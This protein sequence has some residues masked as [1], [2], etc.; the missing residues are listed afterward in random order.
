MTA[1]DAYDP[2]FFRAAGHRLVD[3]LSDYLQRARAGELPVLDWTAPRELDASVPHGFPELGDGDVVEILS[4]VVERSNHLHHPSYVG[5]QVAT[6]LPVAALAE[7]TTALLNN[8]MAIYEMGP[9]QT[10]MERRVVAFL[11]N[12]VGLPGEADGILT[13]GGSLGNLTALLAARRVASAANDGAPPERLAILA[14]D[15]AHYSIA[16]AT[17]TLGLGHGAAIAVPSDA[18]F[19]LSVEELSTCLR[20]AQDE[21][22]QVL[23]VV[24][25]SCSTA[26]GSFDPLPEIADFCAEHGLW[27]HVDAAH[28]ASLALSDRHRD[29]LRGIERADSVVWD[30]HKMMA[31]PA[32]NTAVLFRDRGHSYGTFA[33]EAGYLFASDPAHDEWWNIGLRTFECTKRG[34]GVTAYCMLTALGTA[35]FGDNVDQLVDRT[36]E[37]AALLDRQEDFEIATQPEANIL[38]FRYTGGTAAGSDETQVRLRQKI[39]EGGRFYLVTARLRGATWLRV[40]LM[41][42]RTSTEDLQRLLD[43]VRAH[44]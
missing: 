8:G 36:A 2:E 13:H 44:G 14:S 21:G 11:A 35:W 31:L 22:R 19:R 25:S 9:M 3:R 15:Q 27:L 41:N 18:R 23:A 42:P 29:R 33:Q 34:M 12:A 7:M 24:A 5:H 39:V 40:T 16:R 32:L 20:Q 38:C 17:Q 28:G 30:L 6:T 1:V 4:E 43:E 10:V 26:T 37:L